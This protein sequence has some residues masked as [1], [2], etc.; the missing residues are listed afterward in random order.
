MRLRMVIGLGWMCCLLN[1]ASCSTK[2]ETVLIGESTTQCETDCVAV[3]KGF[4]L[5][6]AKLFDALKRTKEALKVCTE[7]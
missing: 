6:H 2:P 1:I 7:K 5:E 3:S 4:I